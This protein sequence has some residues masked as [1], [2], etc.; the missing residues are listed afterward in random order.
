[1]KISCP[2]SEEETEGWRETSNVE[3]HHLRSSSNIIRSTESRPM[4]WAGHTDRMGGKKY[5][6]R[7]FV[8]KCEGKRPLG[9]PRRE[10][11]ENINMNPK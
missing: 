9:K 6:K 11:Y 8:E 10:W 4:R 1:M 2:K 5:A 3:I 7:V